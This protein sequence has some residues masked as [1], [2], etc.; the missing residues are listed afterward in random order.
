MANVIR[1]SSA[2]SKPKVKKEEVV[3][4]PEVDIPVEEVPDELDPDTNEIGEI[5]FRGPDDP[6]PSSV[7]ELDPNEAL[8][9]DGPTAG[10]VVEWK[11]EYGDVYVTSITLDDHYMWKTLN[12][13]EYRRVLRRIEELNEEGDLTPGELNMVQ[14]ELICELCLLFPQ[15]TSQELIET[16]A[17]IPSLLSQQIME[18]SGFTSIDVR[19]L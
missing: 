13:G 11:K 3:V 15:K 12:R 1:P 16:Q 5:D 7:E 8:W 4:E 17:G 14:E 2:A 10:Q 18:S 19:G 9:T 6:P